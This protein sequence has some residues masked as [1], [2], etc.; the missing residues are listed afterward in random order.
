MGGF[1]LLLLCWLM[2][3]YAALRL[4]CLAALGAAAAGAVL[5]VLSM[6]GISGWMVNIVSNLLFLLYYLPLQNAFDRK[7]AAADVSKGTRMLGRV[8]AYAT[9]AQRGASMLGFLPYF[10]LLYTSSPDT[11]RLWDKT[12][13]EKLDKD[14][15]RRDMGGVE[16]AYQEK[17]CIRDRYPPCGACR[18]AKAAGR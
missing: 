6:A 17:M 16:E 2:S 13:G 8:W 5:A 11:C 7:L 3:G 9:L 12:T 10:C 14:R 18:A 1:A 4:R 15:F